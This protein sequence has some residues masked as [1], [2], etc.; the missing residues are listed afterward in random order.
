MKKFVFGFTT[1]A[2]VIAQAASSTTVRL[3]SPMTA[4][5]TTLKAGEYKLLIDG[6]NSV[7][8]QSEGKKVTIPATTQKGAGKFH[9]TMMESEGSTIKSI[10]VGGTDTTIV[11]SAATASAGGN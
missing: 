1:L 5:G 4:A 10:H 7:T 11:F 3:T 2:L 8:F 9:E 6:D